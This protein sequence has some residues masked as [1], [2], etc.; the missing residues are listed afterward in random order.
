[1]RREPLDYDA[2]REPKTDFHCVVCQK[3]LDPAKRVRWVWVDIEDMHAIHPEDIGG[4]V[5]DRILLRPIGNDCAKKIGPEFTFE[6][7]AST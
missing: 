2:R 3:D 6:V 4:D 7:E 5:D 1:M